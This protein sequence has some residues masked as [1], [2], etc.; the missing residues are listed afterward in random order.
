MPGHD[1][2]V[3]RNRKLSWCFGD[4]D[5]MRIVVAEWR[6]IVG[7]TDGDMAELDGDLAHDRRGPGP[8]WHDQL[9]CRLCRGGTRAGT[10]R[11]ID[12]GDARRGRLTPTVCTEHGRRHEVGGRCR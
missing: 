2:R 10:V 8:W 5:P 3:G 4:T 7:G 9:E 11:M 6:V 1:L 12:V